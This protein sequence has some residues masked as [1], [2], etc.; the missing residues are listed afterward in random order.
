MNGIEASEKMR[1]VVTQFPPALLGPVQ[2]ADELADY[3]VILKLP[4]ACINFLEGPV[5]S[6]GEASR[7]LARF[8]IEEAVIERLLGDIDGFKNVLEAYIRTK[9]GIDERSSAANS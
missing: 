3:P 8:V 1:R 7:K 4:R 2:G 9:G 6:R 5:E